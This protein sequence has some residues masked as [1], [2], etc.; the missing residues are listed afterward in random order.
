MGD[1]LRQGSLW[2]EQMRTAHCSSPVTYVRGAE[3]HQVN[4]TFGRKEYEVRDDY[5]LTVGAQVTDFL[6]LAADFPFDEPKSGDRITADGRVYEVLNL[7]GEGHW[8][9]SDPYRTTMRIHA[10]EVGAE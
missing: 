2:L 8:L 4:A 3:A 1:L 10:K 5:G 7:A 9:W 6:I